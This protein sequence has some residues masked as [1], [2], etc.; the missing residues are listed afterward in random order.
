MHLTKD[1][2]IVCC[3]NDT[4][5]NYCDYGGKIR[6]MTLL[7][8]RKR[9][10]VKGNRLSC[11]CDDDLRIPTFLEYLN[12]CKKYGSIPFIELKTNDVDQVLFYLNKQ[13]FSYKNTIISSISVD[14]LKQVRDID[15]NMFIHWLFADENQLDYF[16]KL[17]NAGVSLN[18]ADAKSC[19][20]EK[21]K[22]A[23]DLGLKIC[24][25]ACD[26]TETLNYMKKNKFRLF[27]NKLFAR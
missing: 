8:I 25:R 3:H 21:I 18:Y 2:Q 24:L 16:S 20:V 15:K 10:I 22:K 12:I 5:D 4:L 1:R 27:A 13:E 7:D 9:K 23:K 6:D 19:P 17:S 14:Y 11:F 26:N